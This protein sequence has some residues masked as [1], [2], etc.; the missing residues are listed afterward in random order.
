VTVPLW[1]LAA[2]LPVVAAT[3]VLLAAHRRFGA[4]VPM[5][6]T[7]GAVLVD[8][9]HRGLGL[10]LVGWL[11]FAFVW[12]LAHQLGF[13]W[14]DGSLRRAPA[15]AVAMVVG[16]V[17]GLV[18][19]TQVAGY[20]VAMV[21]GPG[22]GETSNAPPSLAIVALAVAQVGVVLLAEGRL[23]RWLRRPRVWAAVAVVNLHA[24]T[25]FAWHFAVLVAV[26][27]VA[28][29]F[30]FFPQPEPASLAW[31]L[32]RP[33]WLLVLTV[34]LVSVVAVMRRH[35]QRPVAP[36]AVGG[37]VARPVAGVVAVSLGLRL[38]AV[39]GL[40]DGSGPFGL[41]AGALALLAVGGALLG[42][43][44]TWGRTD[45]VLTPSATPRP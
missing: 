4:T 14:R 15:A 3:P 34:V 2:Y 35:E 26:T 7:T 42:V 11:N 16:G 29:P 38:L 19:L 33:A 43:R 23:E 10:P 36:E 21:G 24:M 22:A 37:G 13:A 18:T 27:A 25:L 32:W 8:L 41:P 31:W 44:P 5:A 28:L 12:P 9:G 45:P 17:A 20:P 6:L 40:G 1:F 39:D 30:G